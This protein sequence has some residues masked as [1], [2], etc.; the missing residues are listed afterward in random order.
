MTASKRLEPLR[1]ALGLW[2]VLALAVAAR[3]LVSPV[4][5]SVF[6]IFAA[7]ADHWWADLPLYQPYPPLDTY[8]YPPFFAVLL[9]PF[10]QLGLRV[11]GLLWTGLSLAALL[12]GLW[13]YLRDVGPGRWTQPRVAAFL[14]L[15]GLGALRGLWN[16]QSN[17]LVVGMLLL[18]ASA[19]AR[20]LAADGGSA[21]QGG[22]RRR[23]WRA[24]IL[25]AL[26]VCL[27]L[28]PLAPA[29]LLCALWPRRLASRFAV[30]VAAGFLLPFLTRPPDVVLSHYGEWLSHLKESGGDR[31][32]GFRDGW[33]VWLAARHLAGGLH[34][35][36]PLCE[37]IDGPWY[38]LA[39]L[40]SAAGVL[41]WCLWQ[42]RRSGR[43]G[44]GAPWLVHVTLSAGMTWL[45]LFGP[46]VEH[47]TYVFL[48]PALAWAVVQREEWARGRLLLAAA[49]AL[50][51]V[52]GW[53]AVSRQATAAWPG[54]GSLLVATLPVGTTLFL[55]W[56]LG[57]TA[58][59]GPQP[60]RVL[61]LPQGRD[62]L[63]PRDWSEA[64]DAGVPR[65][66]TGQ[67]TA[68]A[69]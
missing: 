6:P 11:G 42:R 12:G 59:C 33:T 17:A 36:V 10:A 65:H 16:A 5:H 57:Y 61:P 18:A 21:P 54:G 14:A 25:L 3:T 35:T 30:A 24:A 13:C 28:T 8:R 19:L 48:A 58:A 31:W 1:L 27:K 22:A 67:P 43:L 64:A 45:M 39:Q 40:L 23:W 47:A 55:A 44:L 62:A 66:R 56:L 53:G 9:T 49:V 2:L 29:L 34:G 4:R 50:V 51:F 37:P 52:L 32:L 20:A 68:A 38:R 69:S 7:S 46:A 41:A 60:L 26:P 63:G 15:G